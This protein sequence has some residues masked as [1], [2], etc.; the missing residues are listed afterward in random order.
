M[1]PLEIRRIAQRFREDDAHERQALLRLHRTASAQLRH[2]VE[3]ASS[4]PEVSRVWTWGSILHPE[5]FRVYSD[6][7]ICIE[8]VEDPIMWSSIE[9]R[10]LEIVTFPL[11]LVRW[12]TL[13]DEDRRSIHRNGVLLY[14][15]D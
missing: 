10:L 8:G 4:F 2:S 12:E 3:A 14:E 13:M 1:T 6:I 5:R 15:S 7:D 9:S 11:D